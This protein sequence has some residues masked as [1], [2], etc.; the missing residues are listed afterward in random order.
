MA[1]LVIP[2]TLE[3]RETGDLVSFFNN[4]DDIVQKNS[5]I[6]DSVSDDR[7]FGAA[8]SDPGRNI[9]QNQADGRER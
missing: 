4:Y 5:G 6:H 8:M 7:V 3:S 2:K 9:H 1:Q